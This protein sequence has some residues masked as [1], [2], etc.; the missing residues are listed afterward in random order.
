MPVESRSTRHDISGHHGGCFPLLTVLTA[1]ETL[2]DASQNMEIHVQMQM[3]FRFAAR[4]LPLVHLPEQLHP[5]VTE[6]RAEMD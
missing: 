3:H 2:T 4:H 5:G 6:I 1:V